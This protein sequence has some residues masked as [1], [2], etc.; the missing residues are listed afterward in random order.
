[1]DSPH[2]FREPHRD[3][4]LAKRLA[5]LTSDARATLAAGVLLGEF[6]AE[7]LTA[8]T[9]LSEAA[10]AAAIAQLVASSHFHAEARSLAEPALREPL[11]DMM[12]EDVA[13]AV[14]SALTAGQR[15]AERFEHEAAD[16]YLSAGLALLARAREDDAR[17]DY[18]SALADVR[19][20]SGDAE[21]ALPLYE[22][23]IREAE[24]RGELLRLAT[25]LTSLAKVQQGLGRLSEALQS[26]ERSLDVSL[27]A[28]DLGNAG[29]CLMTS[30]RIH[31]YRGEKEQTHAD[32]DH[33]LRLAREA[34][35]RSRLAEALALKGFLLVLVPERQEEGLDNLHA[36]IELLITLGDRVGLNMSYMLLG[37]AL[38]QLGDY[39]GARKSFAQA[40]ALC[41]EVGNRTEEGIALINLAIA[42]LEL[43]DFAEAGALAGEAR[44]LG[45]AIDQDFHRVLA[46]ALETTAAAL[47]GRLAGALGALDAALSQA[48]ALGNKYLEALVLPYVMTV[49]LFAGRLREAI[50][51]GAE[52]EALHHQESESRMHAELAEAHGRLGETKAAET[53]AEAAWQRASESCS[54]GH[55]AWALRARALV[56]FYRGDWE[57]ARK[58]ALSS[59][60]IATRLELRYLGALLDGLLGEIDR[61]EGRPE[62][63]KHFKAMGDRARAL[64]LPLLE[65]AS[66][67]GLAAIEPEQASAAVAL[68]KRILKPLSRAE[69]THFLAHGPWAALWS[70]LEGVNS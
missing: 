49:R 51:A 24:S 65:A 47:Q 30:A 58:T 10:V 9:G 66:L 26:C 23:A 60:A 34:D 33:A 55:M 17:L 36:S 27:Q 69:R 21:G 50:A 11:L 25:L 43:G 16:R 2:P 56:A 53:H 7:L 13:R 64:D 57:L 42:A 54:Q 41:Q 37:D 19:R 48:R 67:A 14:R 31:L 59:Q 3:P 52:L 44:Q 22:E 61:G 70:G 32:L 35:D 68:L 45:E 18:L 4:R 40:R 1:M 20:V 12:P 38:S 8:L 62:A 39:T 15:S 6:D 28:G 46:S 5:A 63:A 29:R